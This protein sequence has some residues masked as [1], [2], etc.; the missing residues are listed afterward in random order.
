MIIYNVDEFKRKN[1]IKG[2]KGIYSCLHKMGLNQQLLRM[3]DTKKVYKYMTSE[4]DIVLTRDDDRETLYITTGNKSHKAFRII[5]SNNSFE[6]DDIHYDR[7]GNGSNQ[8]GTMIAT[9]YALVDGKVIDSSCGLKLV[10]EGNDAYLTYFGDLSNLDNARFTIKVSPYTLTGYR[11]N[12]N[13]TD[14][15][16]TNHALD[17]FRISHLEG[18]NKINGSKDY[19]YDCDLTFLEPN[20]VFIR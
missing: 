9:K 6:L 10:V 19:Y 17:C 15:L 16:N 20:D 8:S 7:V 11:E 5:I 4:R 1:G 12:I 2:P 13:I 14:T 3:I 18:E